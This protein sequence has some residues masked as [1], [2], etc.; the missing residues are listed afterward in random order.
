MKRDPLNHP[1]LVVN[2]SCI[3]RERSLLFLGVV[4]DENVSW[5]EH[6]N[7]IQNK[8]SKK[9]RFTLQS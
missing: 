6:I 8:I 9:Y 7:I 1:N 3:V 2:N 5:K 4:I